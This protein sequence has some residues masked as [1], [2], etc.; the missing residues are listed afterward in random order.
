[1]GISDA[2]FSMIRVIISI[3][4]YTLLYTSE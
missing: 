1:M 2:G 3:E 4:D